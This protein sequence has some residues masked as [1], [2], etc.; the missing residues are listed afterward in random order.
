MTTFIDLGRNFARN[1]LV[2]LLAMGVGAVA[3]AQEKSDKAEAAQSLPVPH[4]V[5]HNVSQEI[6]AFVR[7]NRSLLQEDS[8]KYY[9]GIESILTPSLNLEYITQ[10]VM[11]AYWSKASQQQRDRFQ[12]VFSRSMIVTYGKGMANYADLSVRVLPAD[13]PVPEYGGTVVIQEIAT[14]SATEKVVYFMG[15]AQGGTW[16]VINVVYEGVNLRDTSQGQF[17]QLATENKGDIDATI[18]GWKSSE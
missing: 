8:R 15:R 12:K 16:Q 4:Q 6:L 11:G 5:I 1:A 9:D 14:D 17:A 10:K 2:F 7:E 18:A 3:F 13:K